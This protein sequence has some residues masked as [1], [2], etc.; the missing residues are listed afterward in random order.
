MQGSYGILRSPQGW[1]GERIVFFGSM[2]MIGI[3]CEWRMTWTKT[4]DDQF[5]FINQERNEIGSW[6]YIDEWRFKRKR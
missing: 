4:G 3:N 6:V 1:I 5:G 2:T